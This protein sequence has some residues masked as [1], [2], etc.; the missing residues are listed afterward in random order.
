MASVSQS[1]AKV[2]G[3]VT[4]YGTDVGPGPCVYSLEDQSAKKKD[5]GFTFGVS[6]EAY[7]KVSLPS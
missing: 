5:V 6:H 3:I 1:A 4:N 2:S 7:K